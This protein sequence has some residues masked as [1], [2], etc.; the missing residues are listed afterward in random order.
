MTLQKPQLYLE[1]SR[2]YEPHN[3]FSFYQCEKYCTL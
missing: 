1:T 2:L 3:T